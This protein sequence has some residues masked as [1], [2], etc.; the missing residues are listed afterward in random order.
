VHAPDDPA[1][2][3]QRFVDALKRRGVLIS[4]FYNTPAPSFRIGCIGA[5]TPADMRHAVG[6]MAEALNE[7]GINRRRAA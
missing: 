4:N 3:L 5:I 1:W 7:L 6:A 2:D